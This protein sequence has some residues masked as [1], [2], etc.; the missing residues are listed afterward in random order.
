MEKL[1]FNNSILY[2]LSSKIVTQG[3]RRVRIIKNRAFPR[4]EEMKNTGNH[5]VGNRTAAERASAWGRDT[6]FP[7]LDS[8]GESLLHK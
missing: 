6:E 1:T 5:R 2:I 3:L 4:Q 8:P 7:P